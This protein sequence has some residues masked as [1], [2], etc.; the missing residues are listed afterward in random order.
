[1]QQQPQTGQP[2]VQPQQPQDTLAMA[3]TPGSLQPQV[4]IQQ[5]PQHL[6]ALC[7]KKE[8]SRQTELHISFSFL[9]SAK[10]S[11]TKLSH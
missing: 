3:L 8:K 9:F 11:S 5:A 6:A 7:K 1:M 2:L 10:D 4:Q